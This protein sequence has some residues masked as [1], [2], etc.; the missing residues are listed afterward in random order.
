MSMQAM[1]KIRPGKRLRAVLSKNWRVLIRCMN[2]RGSDMFFSFF[3][4]RE[5]DRAISW[6]PCWGYGE[7]GRPTCCE[8]GKKP[9][10]DIMDT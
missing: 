6:Q 4:N 2:S 1:L 10:Q 7:K 5:D 3:D 9:T 8:R